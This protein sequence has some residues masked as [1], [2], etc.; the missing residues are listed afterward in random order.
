MQHRRRQ[1][2]S[3]GAGD[4]YSSSPRRRRRASDRDQGA[5][6]SEPNS[7]FARSLLAIGRGLSATGLPSHVEKIPNREHHVDGEVDPGVEG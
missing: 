6:H 2:P 4:S 3:C 7:L 5:R 1:M